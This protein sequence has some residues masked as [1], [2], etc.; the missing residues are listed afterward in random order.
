M[1][2]RTIKAELIDKAFSK[3]EAFEIKGNKWFDN[4]LDNYSDK[5]IEKVISFYDEAKIVYEELDLVFLMDEN[6]K[7]SSRP[8]AGFKGRVVYEAAND[9][10]FKAQL[11]AYLEEQLP[12]NWRIAE[13]VVE[14]SISVYRRSLQS[15]NK[16]EMLLA[17]LGLMQP[18]KKPDSDN[19]AK[20]VLDAFNAVLY[21]DD[22]QNSTLVV[23]KFYSVQPRIEIN[24]RYS[25]N[26]ISKK[27]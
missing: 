4:V 13:G 24:L 11:R 18:L 23:Q 6:P 2:D 1:D 19:Y 10:K 25:Q 8:R 14:M 9:K 22:G 12:K 17:E 3:F 21:L 20:M 27:Q 7:A 26:K 15:F 16:N 5:D